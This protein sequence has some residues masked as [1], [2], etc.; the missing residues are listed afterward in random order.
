MPTPPRPRRLNAQD[1]ELLDLTLKLGRNFARIGLILTVLSAAVFINAHVSYRGA[2]Y[3]TAALLGLVLAQG[4]TLLTTGA[5]IVREV[6]Q[7]KSAL[8]SGRPDPFL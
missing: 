4:L 6:E 8:L 3:T 2:E 5:K 7:A 1:V